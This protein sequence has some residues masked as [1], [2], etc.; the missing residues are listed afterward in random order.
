MNEGPKCFGPSTSKVIWCAL[1]IRE[2]KQNAK[3]LQGS[4]VTTLLNCNLKIQA[5]DFV[6]PPLASIVIMPGTAEQILKKRCKLSFKQYKSTRFETYTRS[7]YT[8]LS[9][10]RAQ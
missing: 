4:L 9:M 7:D 5:R 8:N 1:S 6:A 3:L 10:H 2:I